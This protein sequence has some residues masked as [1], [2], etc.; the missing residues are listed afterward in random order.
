M[1]LNIYQGETLPAMIIADLNDHTSTVAARNVIQSI[2][3][4]K[5]KLNPVVLQATTPETLDDDLG[6]F[7]L[8]R[9]DWTYPKEPGQKKIDLKTG[10]HVSGYNAKD[11]NKVISCTVSHM[12]CWYLAVVSNCPVCVLEHDAFFTRRFVPNRDKSGQLDLKKMGIIGLNDPRGATRKSA[13]Y[14]QKVLDAP[15]TES[16]SYTTSYVDAP[17]VDD[18]QYT[19][20]GLAGNSAY[21]V[22]PMAAKSL[23]KKINEI[24]LWPNDALMCKQMFPYLK[25]AYPFY[26]K[27]QGVKSTTQG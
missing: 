14:L 17:W 8:K 19:P 1:D 25:Q 26:T 16:Y 13:V 21:V 2:R 6:Q 5:S 3:Q 7:N 22:S 15:R 9:S 11:I 23:L 18:D 27:L 24:G 4:T 12:R 10:L 20:Q